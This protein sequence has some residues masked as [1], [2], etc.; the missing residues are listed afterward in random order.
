MIYLSKFTF[1]KMAD[2]NRMAKLSLV[3]IFI[4]IQSTMVIAQTK[5]AGGRPDIPGTLLLEVG[6]NLASETPEDFKPAVFG[7]R[8]LNVYYQY[9]IQLP[10]FQKKISLVPGIGFGFDRFKFSNNYTL[11]YESGDLTMSKMGLDISKSQFNT[12]YFD[13]PI[14]IMYTKKVDDPNRSLKVSLGFRTGVLINAFTKIRYN[15]DGTDIKLKTKQA[16]DVNTLRYGPYAKVG[17]GNFSL[18]TYSNMS[19]LFKADKGPDESNI[20]SV[21]IGI[22]LG[23]F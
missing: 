1:Y 3:L 17:F 23:G 20:N 21:T 18:F 19:T 9:P 4:M 2:S 11:A 6:V 15:D 8:T 22:S 5:Y 10:I 14:E 7:S 12:N 13:V 16:W